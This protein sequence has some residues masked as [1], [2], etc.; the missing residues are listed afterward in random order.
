[1]LQR[2]QRNL[3]RL[4]AALGRGDFAAAVLKKLAPTP[5]EHRQAGSIPRVRG[6]LDELARMIGAQGSIPAGQ[7]FAAPR[8]KRR[9]WVHPGACGA[10]SVAQHIR[11]LHYCKQRVEI[12]YSR[13]VTST[14]AMVASAAMVRRGSLEGEAG[15]LARRLRYASPSFGRRPAAWRRVATDAGFAIADEGRFN[16]NWVRRPATA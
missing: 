15:R 1:M 4:R 2:P 10:A 14:P 3:P 6:S 13:R 12:D 8:H 9:L 7:P 5:S 11:P 16:G